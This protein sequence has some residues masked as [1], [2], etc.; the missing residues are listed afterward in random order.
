MM[1][2]LP[3]TLTCCLCNGGHITDPPAATTYASVVSIESE[4]I[5]LT[6]AGLNNLLE[7]LTADIKN[8]YLNA[9]ITEK[10]W[11]IC[12]PKCGPYLQ[13]KKVI[14]DHV[15]FCNHLTACMRE[16]DYMSCL[17]DP[18]A[19]MKPMTCEDRFEYWEYILI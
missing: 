5:A 15:M 13:G 19:W 16:L 14:N 18:D 1:K 2:T 3:H 11:M 6:I 12:G 9:P 4:F 7:I 8:A 17:A 10:V